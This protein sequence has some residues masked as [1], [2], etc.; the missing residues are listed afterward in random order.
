MRPAG[1]EDIEDLVALHEDPLVREVFGSPSRAEIEEWVGRAEDEWAE[2]G[3]G[4]MTLLDRESAA[5]LGRCGLK[6]WPEFGEVEVGWVLAPAGRG[7][8]LATRTCSSA[9]R[10]SSTPCGARI[11]RGP[12]G[13]PHPAATFASRS[14]STSRKLCIGQYFGPHIE[15]NS[16]VLK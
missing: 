16:A 6:W 13:R 5:F 9:S 12:D 2:R 8:G 10:S 1:A 15:Q 14:Q 11:D 4:R 3:H 7:R